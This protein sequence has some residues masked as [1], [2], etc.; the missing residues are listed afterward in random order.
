MKI[1]YGFPLKEHRES[2]ILSRLFDIRILQSTLSRDFQSLITE[3]E[4]MAGTFHPGRRN[5]V[6]NLC[7]VRTGAAC[8][9]HTMHP[10]VVEN[11]DV[12]HHMA[13]IFACGA[14][15]LMEL[16]CKNMNRY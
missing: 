15:F 13:G 12:T 14:D 3:A 6:P 4:V 5:D 11:D 1:L 16:F 10:E 8:L 7:W 9:D 2:K